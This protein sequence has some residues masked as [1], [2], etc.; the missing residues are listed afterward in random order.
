MIF[1][2]FQIYYTKYEQFKIS[3]AADCYESVKVEDSGTE[4]SHD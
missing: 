2:N 1:F 4:M 3:Y